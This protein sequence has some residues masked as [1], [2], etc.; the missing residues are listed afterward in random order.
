[1]VKNNNYFLENKTFICYILIESKMKP[2]ILEITNLKRMNGKTYLAEISLVDTKEMTV[3]PYKTIEVEAINQEF[4]KKIVII[5]MEEMLAE[6]TEN[7]LVFGIQKLIATK[8]NYTDEYNRLAIKLD[9]V[10]TEQE[11]MLAKIV[12][13][14]QH[15]ESEGIDIKVL[16]TYVELDGELVLVWAVRVYTDE[17]GTKWVEL[18]ATSTGDEDDTEWLSIYDYS[19]DAAGIVLSAIMDKI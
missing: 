1:L 6:T 14:A 16:D 4:A 11:E 9:E 15:S 13:K 2:Y 3:T 5:R 19:P 18:K 8:I 7:N 10:R 12:E 17:N